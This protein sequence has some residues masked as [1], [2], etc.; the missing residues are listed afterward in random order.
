[1][2]KNIF[3]DEPEDP[4]SSPNS[5]LANFGKRQTQPD[6]SF[7]S[8]PS[9]QPR[10]EEVEEIKEELADLKKI[11]NSG[12]DPRTNGIEEV[13]SATNE[14][15]KLAGK[16]EELMRENREL[17]A[18]LSGKTGI[19]IQQS[20]R[21]SSS[22]S[23]SRQRLEAAEQTRASFLEEE[24]ERDE[25]RKI[26]R[27]EEERKGLLLAQELQKLE[28]RSAHQQRQTET[29]SSTSGSQQSTTGRF[30]QFLPNETRGRQESFASPP[31][32]AEQRQQTLYSFPRDQ[33]EEYGFPP[34]ARGFV[35]YFSRDPNPEAVTEVLNEFYSKYKGN[36]TSN[37]LNDKFQRKFM[38]AGINM[39]PAALR[40]FLKKGNF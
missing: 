39:F 33:E 13:R 25:R 9:K 40:D 17:N 5:V 29:R 18:E 11:L 22:S 15:V 21:P 27:L 20:S 38:A 36:A 4:F 16:L 2:E 12:L 34:A 26:E 32:Q 30:A 1:M 35:K 7:G 28:D 19:R 14:I 10:D 37:E 3:M 31:P 6:F 24:R 23:S 8:D